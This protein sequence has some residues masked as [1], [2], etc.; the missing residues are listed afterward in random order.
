VADATT[1]YL[2]PSLAETSSAVFVLP[3]IVC[4]AA[5]LAYLLTKG[6]RTRAASPAH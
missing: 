5:L 2:A 3:E 4:E 1:Q 6:V